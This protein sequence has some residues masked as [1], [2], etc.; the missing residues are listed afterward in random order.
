MQLLQVCKQILIK[1]FFT[2]DLMKHHNLLLPLKYNILTL[3][4]IFDSE[5]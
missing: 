5:V 3:S 1:I 2:Q 4:F